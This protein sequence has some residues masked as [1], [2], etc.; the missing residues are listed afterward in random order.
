VS[1]GADGEQGGRV[2]ATALGCEPE[3]ILDLSSTL[4]RSQ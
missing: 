2:A 1:R 4:T 3:E